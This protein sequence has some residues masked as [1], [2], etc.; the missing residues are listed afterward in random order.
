VLIASANDTAD[1]LMHLNHG[2]VSLLMPEEVTAV[3]FSASS[4]FFFSVTTITYEPLHLA[5]WNFAWT[6][7][8]TTSTRLLYIKVVGQGHMGFC[9]FLSARYQWAVVSLEG[10]FCF[11]ISFLF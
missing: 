10:G 2:T 11:F 3:L 9:A 4:Q 8:L 6:C 1:N 5:W 7:I